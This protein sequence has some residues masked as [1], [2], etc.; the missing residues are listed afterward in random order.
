MCIAGRFSNSE[1]YEVLLP[2]VA[3]A[4][5][6]GLSKKLRMYHD[7]ALKIRCSSHVKANLKP[8]LW[9]LG[10][11]PGWNQMRLAYEGA[12]KAMGQGLS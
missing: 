2:D 1:Q 4:S 12:A 10:I 5:L 9:M 11:A 8:Q 3:P 6:D 7:E